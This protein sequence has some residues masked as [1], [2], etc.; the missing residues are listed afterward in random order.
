MEVLAIKIGANTP[1]KIK[2]L[3]M[4][5]K[6]IYFFLR[7]SDNTTRKNENN[8]KIKLNFQKQVEIFKTIVMKSYD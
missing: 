3:S 4:S 7:L 8:Q 6:S 2:L 1:T 5:R